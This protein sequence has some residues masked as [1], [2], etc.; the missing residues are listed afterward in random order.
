MQKLYHGLI[1]QFKLIL[2][3]KF[4]EIGFDETTQAVIKVDLSIINHMWQISDHRFRVASARLEKILVY[5]FF[6]QF[7]FLLMETWP[8]FT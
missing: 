3:V 1:G 5:A 7:E 8:I 6:T 4:G 2:G